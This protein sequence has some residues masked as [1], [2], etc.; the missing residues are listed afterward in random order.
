MNAVGHLAGHPQH[1]RID[2]GDINLRIRRVDRPGAPLGRD[3][4]QFVEL[5]VMVERARPKGREA[6]FDREHVVPQPWAGMLERHAV[7][8][9]HM[10]PHLSA[11]TE[12]EFPARGLLQFPRRRGR[13]ERAAR[14]R[15]RDAGRQLQ[16]GRCLRGNRGVEVGG[17]ACL[18]EEHPGE[19]R[20]LRSPGEVADHAER[21]R[22]GHHVD[23]H[24][25]TLRRDAATAFEIR[26]VRAT[27][28]QSSTAMNCLRA[29]E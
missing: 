6:G 9:H 28:Q 10:G 22:R 16:S 27:A 11:E 13:H 2:R 3:E 24:S 20:G 14:E 18:G 4:V 19:V 1:P 29:L 23:V 15:H 21:L 25:G 12:P 17:S 7:S 8:A 5:A 26:P